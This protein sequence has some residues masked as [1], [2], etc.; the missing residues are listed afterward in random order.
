MA[1][2]EEKFK[3]LRLIFLQKKAQSTLEYALI[4]PLLFLM[5]LGVWELALMWHQYNSLEFVAKEISANIA[6]LDN[7]CNNSDVTN[8]I[9]EKTAILHPVPLTYT[10]KKNGKV[11]SFTSIQQY[12]K[13]PIVEA[14]IDCSAMNVYDEPLPILQMTSAHKLMF[15]SASLPNFKTGERIEI[16]PKNVTFVSSKNITISKY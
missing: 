8:I 5:I 14:K 11:T 15:F 6:L 13:K 12:D 4:F 10:I 1:R 3:Y 9:I 16:I 7:P 2:N